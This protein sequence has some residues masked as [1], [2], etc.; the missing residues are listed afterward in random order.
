MVLCRRN[1]GL[2]IFVFPRIV[3]YPFDESG[4]PAWLRFIGNT[5]SVC[6]RISA[7][8]R[9]RPATDRSTEKTQTRVTP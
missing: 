4:E 9:Y 1:A 2:A 5:R 7:C 6:A 3:N 8:P